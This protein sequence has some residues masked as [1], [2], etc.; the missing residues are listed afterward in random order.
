MFQIYLP[1]AEISVNLLVMLGLGAAVGFLAG[2][3]GVG[4]GFLVVPALVLLGGLA[5]LFCAMVIDRIAQGM[6]RKKVA[7]G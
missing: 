5:I 7:G 1:I 4:G 3:F 2:M 6:Y